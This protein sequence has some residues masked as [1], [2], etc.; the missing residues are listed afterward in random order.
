MF[1]QFF[2]ACSNTDKENKEDDLGTARGFIRS[3]LD[4]DYKAARSLML[5]D[6]LNMQYLDAFERNYK[7]HMAREDKKGYKEASIK[8]ESIAKQT[9][10]TTVVHYSNSY[11]KKIDSLKVVQ[12]GPQW[13]IDLKYSFS[14]PDSLQQ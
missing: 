11:K 8:I 2:C 13:L 4:G 14:K 9:D 5:Q 7:E 12:Q 10:S 3:A 1:L 6:S